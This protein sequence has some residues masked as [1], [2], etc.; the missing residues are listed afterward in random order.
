MSFPTGTCRGLDPYV[1]P[2]AMS[3]MTTLKVVVL[4]EGDFCPAALQRINDLLSANSSFGRVTIESSKRISHDEAL[5][6]IFQ[7]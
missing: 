7:P 1:D 6:I 5:D 2:P 3:T 4:T